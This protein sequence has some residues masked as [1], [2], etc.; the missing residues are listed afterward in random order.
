MK[1]CY[2]WRPDLPDA[3]D[4]YFSAPLGVLQALPSEADLRPGCPSVYDQGQLGSCTANA[5]AGAHEC[6]QRRQKVP[7]PFTPSRLFIYYNERVIENTVRYDAGA[8]LRDGFKSIAASGVC[9]ESQWK[10][11]VGAFARKPSAA[12]YRAALAHQALSYE[13]LQQTLA[14]L[15][16]C[17]AAGFPFAF[18][19]SVHESFESEE[20][21]RTGIV[22]LPSR[23][24]PVLGGHAVLAVG[25]NDRQQ[26][27]TIRNS[28][29][30][31]WGAKGYGFMPYSYL[32][33]TDL[34]ADFWTLRLVEPG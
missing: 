2:G 29:G 17:I 28:W 12:C 13:R 9:P 16:G 32:T 3:R 4:R 22:P 6:D 8:R 24:E 18:G 10:Y 1:H 31:T 20:V 5:I 23:G 15:R 21:A 34:A 25:Y 27:F 33:E 26:R 11:D 19:F 14:Q 7:E 30:D